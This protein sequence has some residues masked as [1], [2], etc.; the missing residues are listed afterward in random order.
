MFRGSVKSTGYPLH[1]PVSP[2]PPLPCATMC[3]HISTGFYNLSS[4]FYHN[5]QEDLPWRHRGGLMVYLYPFLNLGANG[6]GWL[7]HDPTALPP[8]MTRYPF[9]RGWVGF[10]AGMDGCGKSRPPPLPALNSRTQKGSKTGKKKTRPFNI[11]WKKTTH[12]HKGHGSTQIN[13]KWSYT[14]F[15]PLV[16]MKLLLL[17]T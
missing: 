7:S 1:S 10:K 9:Y 14:L 11:I 3:H 4:Y 2:S 6:N 15:S 17:M 5:R 8:G 12:T 16:V 13:Q